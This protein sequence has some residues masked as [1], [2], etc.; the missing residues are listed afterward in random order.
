ML[1]DRPVPGDRSLVRAAVT[2]LPCAAAD[3]AMSRIRRAL[4]LD[5][6]NP[7]D[8]GLLPSTAAPPPGG[9]IEGS[10]LLITIAARP[11]STSRS[12]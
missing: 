12:T 9:T 3:V 11:R 1:V 2:I 10:A 4:V 7:M 8:S 5:S 6:G